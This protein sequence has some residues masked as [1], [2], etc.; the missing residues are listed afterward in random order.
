MSCSVCVYDGYPLTYNSTR[1]T[2]ALCITVYAAIVVVG[3]LF[4]F[5][6]RRHSRLLSKR[7]NWSTALAAL[8]VILTCETPYREYFG[9][10]AMP[11]ALKA[12]LDYLQCALIPSVLLCRCVG[13][14][15]RHLRQMVVLQNA[16][17]NVGLAYLSAS[18][19]PPLTTV[20]WP[21]EL[22]PTPERGSDLPQG[23]EQPY[24]SHQLGQHQQQNGQQ[25]LQQ[26][27][28][29]QQQLRRSAR[30]WHL[31]VDIV[32]LRLRL[33]T[34]AQLQRVVGW[35]LIPWIAYYFV[36]LGISPE[37]RSGAVGCRLD[38]IDAAVSVVGGLVAGVPIIAVLLRLWTRPDALFM[39][40]EIALQI[41]AWGVFLVGFVYGFISPTFDLSVVNSGYAILLGSTTTVLSSVWLPAI[42]SFAD[43]GSTAPPTLLAELGR[44]MPASSSATN[45]MAALAVSNQTRR[46]SA[47]ATAAGTL[48]GGRA[49]KSSTAIAFDAAANHDLSTDSVVS[50][51]T[52]AQG[53]QAGTRATEPGSSSLDP[54]FPTGHQRTSLPFDRIQTEM[55]SVT[56]I[57]TTD[58]LTLSSSALAAL[59]AL[60]HLFEPVPTEGELV[61]I[62]QQ[63]AQRTLGDARALRLFTGILLVCKSGRRILYEALMREFSAELLGF[64]LACAEV[65]MASS[66]VI[67]PAGLQTALTWGRSRRAALPSVRC[68][69]VATEAS[70][71]SA[72]S[73]PSPD[74]DSARETAAQA[75]AEETVT[76]T[77]DVAHA[78]SEIVAKLSFLRCQFVDEGAPHQIN[79]SAAQVRWETGPLFVVF[80]SCHGTAGTRAQVRALDAAAEALESIARSPVAA[81]AAQP[82]EA[83][84]TAL[85][86]VCGAEREVLRLIVSGPVYRLVRSPPAFDMTVAAVVSELGLVVTARGPHDGTSSM[87]AMPISRDRLVLIPG[88]IPGEVAEGPSTT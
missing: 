23:Q 22:P 2:V 63:P 9:E 69:R 27:L 86:A 7:D 25:Q 72:T 40:T 80:V 48:V 74:A 56:P 17:P 3:G 37:Y 87:P 19:A 67:T 16:A 60:P 88:G 26:H 36:R 51:F 77:T 49:R 55:T 79:I 65:R 13:L 81:P 52:R 35:W 15:A 8:C 30:S 24:K 75:R 43:E 41:A 62:L 28:Q 38:A 61:A 73:A 1:Q 64:M 83:C 29:Q 33:D 57:T 78:I 21:V 42:L 45:D 6:F 11:C 85:R 34:P 14:Y 12:V 71:A 10:A 58:S 68:T 59:A 5:W 70:S 47:T 32:I 4:L 53:H 39:R 76:S 44:Y 54:S 18:D 20:P 46:S 84:T 82:E 50:L 31:A 66:L